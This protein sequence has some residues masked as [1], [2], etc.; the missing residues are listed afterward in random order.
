MKK[1]KLIT[2]LLIVV[3]LLV[4]LMSIFVACVD[5]DK[6]KDKNKDNPGPPVVDPGKKDP[7]VITDPTTEYK[8][9]DVF[10]MIAD[11]VDAPEK[12]L[13]LDFAVV[14][15]AP[16]GKETIIEVKG[17]LKDVYNNELSFIVYQSLAN[18][19]E[20]E[21]V[22]A[23]YFVNDK[24]YADLGPDK[25]L[26][27]LE[28][29]NLNY[30]VQLAESGVG[31]LGDLLG[32]LDISKFSYLIEMVLGILFPT[33]TADVTPDGGQNFTVD[34]EI[35][36]LLQKVPGLLNTFKSLI[37][38]SG[39]PVD[40]EAIIGFVSDILPDGAYKLYSNFD[41]NKKLTYLAL[42]I[43]DSAAKKEVN[44]G[45]TLDITTTAV[46]THIPEIDETELVKFSLT[47]IEFSID[48]LVG[49]KMETVMDAE[50]N[51]VEQPKRLD[52][53][54]VVNDILQLIGNDD[55]VFPRDLL[56]LEGGTGLRLTVAIDL[57]LNYKKEPVDN[58][59][60]A[61]ELFLLDQFGNLADG[62]DAKPAAG[63][64]YLE[65]SL[66]VNLDGLLP[67]YMQN[68]NIKANVN[69]DT[70]IS[71]L[72][73]MITNAIDEALGLDFQDVVHN[74]G[75]QVNDDGSIATASA[76]DAYNVFTSA[77]A[78]V[79][80]YS[81]DEQGN[82]VI[83][84][85]FTNILHSLLSIVGFQDFVKVD[86]SKITIIANNELLEAV[87]KLAG[88]IGF[89]F[90]DMIP[91]IDLTI[92]L[93]EGGLESIAVNATVSSDLDVEVKIHQF[94]VGIED[95]DLGD[96][97]ENG[98]NKD[99]T[100]YSESLNG[101]VDTL[102]SGIMLSTHFA[103]T[104]NQG[105]YNFAPLVASF[106]LPQLADA[107]I[108]WEF[109]DDFVMD[110]SINVQISLDR[111][112]AENST[113]VFELK[114]DED[115][116]I[117]QGADGIKF[118]KD[119]VLIGI[120]GYKNSIYIDLSGFKIANITLPKLK[121]NL[122][123][124]DVVY[125]IIDGVVAQLLE[126]MNVEGGDFAFDFD[127]SELLGMSSA[128]ATAA[129]ALADGNSDLT[130]REE[131]NAI[132]LGINSNAIAP[133][134]SMATVLK[135]I[136]LV[137]PGLIDE[138]R[139]ALNLME[140]NLR[141]SMGKTDGFSFGFTGNLVPVMYEYPVDPLTGK[142]KDSICIFYYDA[143]GNQ[144]LTHDENGN[145][146]VYQ[147]QSEANPNGYVTKKYN[148]QTYDERDTDTVR[149]GED[150][151][152]SLLFEM[153]TPK[154]PV[155]IG[156]IPEDKKFNF[157]AKVDDFNNYRSDLVDAILDVVGAGTLALDLTLY[158]KDNVM[159]LQRLIN[160]VLAN[161]G[162]RLEIP[163]NLSLDEWQT[164]VKLMLQW[165]L[166]LDSSA[167]SAIKI[168]LQYRGK[169]LLGVY[170]YRNNFVIDLEGLGLFSA[171]LVN[172]NLVSNIFS[173]IQGYV[174]QI[175]GM[176]LN[177]II[178]DL[179]GNAGLPTLPS[180]GGSTEGEI[181]TDDSVS[182]IGED[183]EI[184]D[185]VKYLLQGVS[186][187][188]T[189]IG[190]NFTSTLI[191]TLLYELL[192]LNLG[193]DMTVGGSLDLF[194]KEIEDM[195]KLQIGVEDITVDANLEL[196][197]G[198][199]DSSTI[200][201][202]KYNVIPEWDASAGRVLAKTMLDNLDIG[203]TLDISN[204]TADTQNSDVC[205]GPGY[206]RI[207]IWKAGAN[208]RL[209]GAKGNPRVT[210]GALIVGVYSIDGTKF[211][212][213]AAGNQ[214]PIAYITI[215]YTK[216]S[217]QM[218][219]RICSNIAKLAV[220]IGDTVGTIGVDLDLLD[221]LGGMLEGLF[222]Q[223]DGVFD[224]LNAAATSTQAL[225]TAD[226]NDATT[227]EPGPFDEIFANLDI[228]KLLSAGIDVTLSS[229]GNFNVNVGFD[230]YTIN[231]LIDDVLSLVFSGGTGK[232]SIL[233]L[234]TI[235]M[236]SGDY[237]SEVVWN[238]EEEGVFWRSLRD[239]ALSPIIDDLVKFYAINLGSLGSSL[240]SN[241]IKNL[242]SLVISSI[243]PFA[244]F[245]EFNVGLNF[246]DGTFA[247]VYVTGYDRGQDI[248]D[249]DGNVAYAANKSAR[250]S[251]NYTQI[252]IYNMFKA[253]GDKEIAIDGQQGLVTWTDI[254][255][256]IEYTPYIYADDSVGVQDIYNKYFK[257]KKASFQDGASGQ[258]IKADVS[259][260]MKSY[261]RGNS[262][263]T[264]PTDGSINNYSTTPVT[265]DE[266]AVLKEKGTYII[267]ARA[268]FGTTTRTMDI[269]IEALGLG[270][271]ILRVEPFSM[272]VYDQMP[273]FITVVMKDETT[274]KISTDYLQFTGLE[275]AG[276][277]AHEVTA[278]VHFPRTTQEDMQVTV[279][280]L[281]STVTSAIVN[282]DAI[283]A[284]DDVPRLVID[285]YDYELT[286]DSSIMDY[287]SD[288]F[289]FKYIDG[290]ADSILVNGAW[291][292]DQ[293]AVDAFYSRVIDADG[294]SRDVGGT[295]FIVTNT[296]GSGNTLQTVRF[297]I[298]VR[299]KNVVHLTVN[300]EE[301]TLRIDPYQYY[302]YVITGDESLNPFPS[303]AMANYSQT[304]TYIN[305][306]G[307]EATMIDNYNLEA[308]EVF[309]RWNAEQYRDVDFSWDNDNSSNNTTISIYLDND[310]YAGNF[311]WE[312]ST[313]LVVMRNEVQAIYFD[314]ALTQ[315]TYFIDPFE[316]LLDIENGLTPQDIYPSEAN[317][318][319]TNGTVRKMPIQWIGID[320]FNVTDYSSRV[321]QLQV[322]IGFD[323]TEN[324]N[325]AS[326]IRGD[327]EQ[328]VY[329]NV[330]VE[331]L[332]PDGLLVAGSEYSK[333]NNRGDV[334][335]IDPIQY[336]YYG[337]DPFPRTVT[338]VYNNGNRSDLDVNWTFDRS[339]ITMNGGKY[340]ATI[341]VSSDYQYVIDVEV[342]DR[343]NLQSAI[344]S[345][346]IDPYKYA[347]AEDGSRIYSNFA[348][349]S[350][351]YKQI[352][353]IDYSDY[354]NVK[355]IGDVNVASGNVSSEFD[356]YVQYE[357]TY[358]RNNQTAEQTSKMKTLDEVADFFARDAANY[359]IVSA[360]VKQYFKVSVEWDL[361]EI[362]YA[363]TDSYIV[364]MRA[365]ALDASN[366]RTFRINVN[367]MAKE[368]E[369]V[370]D[371]EYYIM[372][373]FG[374]SSLT[375]DQV[376]T[377]SIT[378]NIEV[379]FTDGTT[380]IYECTIDLSTV[381]FEYYN[382][383]STSDGY[384]TRENA[385]INTDDIYD[386]GVDVTVTVCSG[387]IAQ[388]KTIRVVIVYAA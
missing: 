210:P 166:D 35:K 299:T 323:A 209:T 351:L 3:V 270:S 343:T 265:T 249:Y 326:L 14:Y 258:L 38:L 167:R 233:D 205:N 82:F 44:I 199:S 274:R 252:W 294:Y 182:T 33:I 246:V 136:D 280:Y 214:T 304:Y 273:D 16:D 257:D 26:L 317:V 174:G 380:G 263:Y 5:K 110:M 62:E 83:G 279:T 284:V 292:Y 234:S 45:V 126:S 386:Y 335:Y 366:D 213:S 256:Q 175:E 120:Y 229:N 18:Q 278:T 218:E 331:N 378:R 345:V 240:A 344:E 361:T 339:L 56:L 250:K 50:G 139:E 171:K 215:D 41:A 269:E 251:G 46:D 190:L 178:S 181:A 370:G 39:L 197:M 305:E 116:Q 385:A 297:M 216:T 355:V 134:I 73:D 8:I 288:R 80:S 151:A 318:L 306:K 295:A 164:D 204:N 152:F 106:G 325:L 76:Q 379:M 137:S 192:D 170:V 308:E 133:V 49:T 221:M 314:D 67:S 165:D 196:Q 32:G 23:I 313:K 34:V 91:E 93:F 238:R 104:F 356:T 327:L 241:V 131:I 109:T 15:T 105:K 235:D 316:Y 301:D 357:V 255:A 287:V 124:S 293:E 220:D 17:N 9:M 224:G 330:K 108:I 383:I 228:T 350:Y 281:D 223:I 168:E 348:D 375:E 99:N 349:T 188:N 268:K 184:M 10:N 186:L 315:T 187:K 239:K 180:A 261:T 302:M 245:N 143:Q 347:T 337:V 382:L 52:V 300:G 158:T 312:F 55:I 154:H 95:L 19:E 148:Y 231:K 388:I 177:E 372:I 102:L 147:K 332:T 334:F 338:M 138:Y 247:N 156:A 77:N 311:T 207:R 336:L 65:G 47:N 358:I 237:L 333:R 125:S 25:P 103:M 157:T 169:A 236:F 142:Q 225:A 128:P 115:L 203:L 298:W 374:G 43:N 145:K 118:E 353:T 381:N 352:A 296:I 195:L 285:L 48:L 254:P 271:G 321:A 362:N 226:A 2:T 129:V 135:V 376:L 232:K 69:L 328:T 7:I 112:N 31:M 367:V 141:V 346:D 11:G 51:L 54:V 144:L 13:G 360:V 37:D 140:V 162:K 127:L 149:Y 373:D 119:T 74:S 275:P 155:V 6:D 20:R 320:R 117:G 319:F 71:A 322:K 363:I 40:I 159:D 185:L 68:I 176:D 90:P 267:Q 244:V 227:D 53:G 189:G 27:Y 259:F 198:K 63:I 66:Y 371:E 75:M 161:L 57:D 260:Y 369:Y 107:D 341:R 146:I 78:N 243:L 100:K 22:F 368:V 153:G 1:S 179:L 59:R 85:G 183:L 324:H 201:I 264:Y 150:T 96:R 364:K 310:K 309:I 111:N 29:F 173:I 121:F 24:A 36:S 97:I 160:N 290:R 286:E 283:S 92:N 113:L 303:T 114:M 60:I 84:T 272:H 329:V 61:I 212:N 377:K 101:L 307:E 163:V 354:N 262:T 365:K 242:R 89:R 81:M 132:I 79:V 21:K 193:I 340:Q 28:D 276:Y 230:P 86:G 342:L 122:N 58:N 98:I 30:I 194:S 72:V 219:V 172:T 202:D 200:T 88:D 217:K 211:N 87:E 291:Q 94:L 130:S 277:T 123:F 289:F 12:V 4:S 282:G 222:T 384:V 206:L 387:D 248:L 191:N 359:T 266:L 42:N 253:V 64:Y 208:D 70:L